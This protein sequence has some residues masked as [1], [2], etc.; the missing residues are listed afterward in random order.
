MFSAVIIFS[1]S[2]NSKNCVFADGVIVGVVVDV[3]VDVATGDDVTDGVGVIT[4]VPV[5]VTD[6]VGVGVLVGTGVSGKVSSCKKVK[7]LSCAD[8]KLFLSAVCPKEIIVFISPGRIIS[9][10]LMK[11]L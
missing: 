8:E 3:G 9:L 1:F 10:F 2:Y 11:R 6:G 5:G 4:G 7:N